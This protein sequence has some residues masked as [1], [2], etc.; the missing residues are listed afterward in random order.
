M[1]WLCIFWWP[2][3]SQIF[4]QDNSIKVFD[5]LIKIPTFGHM[6]AEFQ[7]SPIK[8][9]IHFIEKISRESDESFINGMIS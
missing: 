1:A 9:L 6:T 3:E 7:G 4:T 2:E 5:N 8:E